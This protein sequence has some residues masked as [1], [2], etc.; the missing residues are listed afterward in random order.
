[1]PSIKTLLFLHASEARDRDLKT[2]IA[3]RYLSTRFGDSSGIEWQL[4]YLL[5]DTLYVARIQ[6]K[7][8]NY[9]IF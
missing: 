7:I 4:D 1:M 2:L 9:G 8:K 3:Q 5:Q 6:I